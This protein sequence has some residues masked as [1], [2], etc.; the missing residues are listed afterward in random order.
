M[1]W[2]SKLHQEITFKYVEYEKTRNC[3]RETYMNDRYE[4][5]YKNK[6]DNHVLKHKHDSMKLR[7]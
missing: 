6:K 2:S 3:K 1:R 4:T 7:T 5:L